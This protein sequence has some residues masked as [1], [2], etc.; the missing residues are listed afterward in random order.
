MS[1]KLDI[2]E[3]VYLH[4]EWSE[5]IGQDEIKAQLE[6]IITSNRVPHAQLFTGDSGYGALPL[7]IEFAITI[8]NPENNLVLSKKLSEKCQNPDLHFIFPVV[9]KSNEK[10]VFSEDYMSEWFYFLDQN[11]YGSYN[12]WFQTIQVGNKQGV[13]GVS[14]IEKL[15]QKMFLKAFGGK[16][17]IC[18]VWGA[19]KMN[20]QAANTFLKLLEEPPQ[21]TYFILIAENDEILL[22]TIVS[23]CQHIEINP[24]ESNAL[25]QVIPNNTKNIRQ[26]VSAACGDYNKLNRLINENQSKNYEAILISGLRKAF[27]AKQDKKMIGA[28]IDWYSGFYGLGREDQKAFLS[29]GIRFFRDA[30]FTNYSLNEIIHFKSQNNFDIS[31]FAPYVNSNNVIKIIS[32]FEETRYNLSRNG[33][34]KMLFSNLAMKLTKFINLS[35]K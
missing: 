11:P 5:V 2:L 3:N 12:E 15:H 16:I 24:I 4:M 9:K 1:H 6:N 30:F 21:K 31:K 20:S 18:I 19:E 7:A 14:Q 35:S 29:F 28:L 27:K 23:R 34:E 13:I 8:L 33:N 32:L 22:P 17:K 26:L 25:I 10:S